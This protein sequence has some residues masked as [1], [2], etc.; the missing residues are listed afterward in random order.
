MSY[1]DTFDHEFV[2]YFGGLPVYH[3]LEIVPVLADDHDQHFGCG[4]ENLVFGGGSGEHPGLVIKDPGETVRC[5][6]RDWLR[7]LERDDPETL[8]AIR[9][10]IEA[11]PDAAAEPEMPDYWEGVFEFAGW[12]AETHKKFR[13]MC[14]SRAVSK[15]FDPAEDGS[16]ENWLSSSIGEFVLLA[17]PELAVEA[18]QRLGELGSRLRDNRRTNPHNFHTNILIL[19]PGYPCWG[20]KET[21]KGVAWGLSAWRIQRADNPLTPR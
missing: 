10:L 21:D 19:P 12:E 5:F 3:P 13:D 1:I 14:T 4:P 8:S 18:I 15:P 7:W 20:R 2:G 16:L 11:W 9:P 17:M 6:V